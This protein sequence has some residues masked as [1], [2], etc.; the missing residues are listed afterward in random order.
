MFGL[1]KVGSYLDYMEKEGVETMEFKSGEMI[2]LIYGE[3]RIYSLILKNKKRIIDDNR[4]VF[5]KRVADY[6]LGGM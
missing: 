3:E 1:N 2:N 4:E 6:C 5:I